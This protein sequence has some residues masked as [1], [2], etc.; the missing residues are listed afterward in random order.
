MVYSGGPIARH[1]YQARIIS[2]PECATS[3]W[4]SAGA[5]MRRNRYSLC[6]NA[7]VNSNP[8]KYVTLTLKKRSTQNPT[9]G[10]QSSRLKRGQQAPRLGGLHRTG[11]NLSWLFGIAYAMHPHTAC[12]PSCAIEGLGSINSSPETL[13]TAPQGKPLPALGSFSTRIPET[14]H[15]NNFA[16]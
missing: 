6:L 2:D 1:T 15:K 7:T 4:G 14:L 16:S 11:N 9:F 12:S 13:G 10:L 3:G 5:S 8:P